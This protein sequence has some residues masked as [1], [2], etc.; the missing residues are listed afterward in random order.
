MQDTEV[1][2]TECTEKILSR[3]G[4]TYEWSLKTMIMG[5]PPMECAR[6]VVEHLSLPITPEEF[7]EELY[8][9][10][11]DMF[12]NARI[13]PG[14]CVCGFF[15]AYVCGVSLLHLYGQANMTP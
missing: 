6:T 9:M 14:V 2:Y 7:H 10:L 5:R 12:P 4:K 8:G 13:M 3:Y 11:Q 15:V 1:L